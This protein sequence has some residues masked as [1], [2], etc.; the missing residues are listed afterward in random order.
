MAPDDLKALA[1]DILHADSE[2]EMYRLIGP[3]TADKTEEVARLV[4]MLR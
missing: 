3:L 2:A 4:E 1:N